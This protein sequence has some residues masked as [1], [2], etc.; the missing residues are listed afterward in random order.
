MQMPGRDIVEH[1]VAVIVPAYNEIGGIEDTL[2]RVRAVLAGLGGT[3]E[4]IVVD[5]GCTD[6]TGA[7]AAACGA[8]VVVHAVNRGYG[9]ALKTGVLSTTAPWVM[10]MDADCSYPP[11][12]IPRLWARRYDADM[13]V[14]ERALS[15]SGVAWARRPAKWIVNRLASY[16]VGQRIPDLNSGQRLMRREVMLKYL[17]LC[18]SGFSF[19]STMTLAMLSNGHQIIYEPIDY[20]P[21]VGNSKM[22]PSHFGT[23]LL[24]VVRAVVLFNPLKVFLPLGAL[25]FALGVLKLAQDL[26]LWH[27]SDT[28]VMAFLAAIVVWAVGLLADMISRLQMQSPSDR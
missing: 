28:A 23:F 14:G 19:T 4:I 17:H 9:A 2:A 27:L 10:I 8:R 1:H 16:L 20:A 11:D 21:R 13:V 15:A 22:R 24:L 6:G 25:L 7:R 18:P 5:D 3:S 26:L 12:A